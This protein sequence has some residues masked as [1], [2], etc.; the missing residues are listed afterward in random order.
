MATEV[1]ETPGGVPFAGFY[2]PEILRELLDYMRANRERLG[3]TDENDFEVHVQLLRAFALVGHLNNTRLDSVATEL[4]LDSATLLES[5]KRLLRLM[6]I[7]LVSA[8]PAVADVVLK[9]SEVTTIDQTGFVPS[10]GEF[11]TGSVPPITFE[12]SEEGI[13]LNRTDRVDFVYGAQQTDSGVGQ[14]YSSS[15]ST[16]RRDAGS[17]PSDVVGQHIHVTGSATKNGGEFRVTQ[18]LSGIDVSVVRMPGSRTP[19]F[20]SEQNLSWSLRKYSANFATQANTPGSFFYPWAGTL[21]AGDCLYVAHTQVM[22][23]QLDLLFNIFAAGITGIWEYFDDDWSAFNPTA[24]DT[25]SVPGSIVFDATELLGPTDARGAQVV[26]TYL[27]TGAQEVVTSTFGGGVNKVQTS[28]LLGQTVGSTERSDYLLKSNWIPFDQLD[29]RTLNLT[30][31]EAAQWALPQTIDRGWKRSDVV[32]AIEAMWLRYRVVSVGTVTLPRLD[33][34]RIDLGDQY[35]YVETTQGETVGPQVIGSSAG[36]ASQQFKL[37][38]IPLIDGTETIEVDE[39]GVGTWLEYARVASF[40]NSGPGSRHYII[41][42]DAAGQGKI[43]FGDGASGK[44]PPAGLGNVRATYRVGCDENGNVGAYQITSNTE[45]ISGV[46]DVFNPRSAHNWRMKDGGTEEDI[47]RVK[48]DAPAAKRTRETAA[49]AGDCALLAVRYWVAGDGTRPIARAFAFE[50]GFGAKTVKLVLVGE[51]GV[52]LNED[53]RAELEGWFNG[54]KYSRPPIYG[55]A[56]MNHRVYAVNFEPVLISVTATVIWSGGS[57]ESIRNQLQ[58]YL[59]PLA[60]DA[61][62]QVTYLWDFGDQISFSRVHSLIHAVSPG[63]VDIPVLLINGAAQSYDLT[64]NELPTSTA[65]SISVTIQEG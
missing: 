52:V 21:V 56:P 25:G 30:A 61:T 23:T 4:L 33:R 20:T 63:I 54:N 17:W 24:V 55:K 22:P 7:E 28:G 27:K 47:K 15:P 60:V 16:F 36:T 41:Q 19:G 2:Y 51:G 13:D 65:A 38:D 43:T 48:R 58:A 32:N 53:Y 50:E 1:I 40:L 35:L 26:I 8:S 42:T 45:G 44:I 34:I 18:R 37:P 10:L 3:L 49:N 39:G 6:G 57:A 31:N 46:S 12:A 11:S 14:V 64:A 9:L 5:V 62:D 29:D 59:T